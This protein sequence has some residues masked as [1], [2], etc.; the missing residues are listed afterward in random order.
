MARAH[1]EPRDN[2]TAPP[3]MTGAPRTEM[4]S[5]P[6]GQ[7]MENPGFP[8]GSIERVVN[9]MID[10]ITSP[11]PTTTWETI[12]PAKAQEWLKHQHND[13]RKLREGWVVTMAMDMESGNWR[14]SHQGIA[15]DWNGNLLDG[16]HRL[17]AIILANVPVKMM[18]TRDLDPNTFQVT[19]AGHSRSLADRASEPWVSKNTISTARRMMAG[20]LARLSPNPS[21]S[22]VM[23]Y[24]LQHKDAIQFSEGL[25]GTGKLGI[26]TAP[27]RAVVARAYYTQNAHTLEQFASILYTG[28]VDDASQGAAVKL[29]DWLTSTASGVG[30]TKAAEQ[31]ARIER[32]LLAFIEGRSL[33]KLYATDQELF[34]APGDPQVEN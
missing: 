30:R 21:D 27:V 3:M 22:Q 29:R 6:L 2:S 28:I 26:S 32:A 25:F 17:N 11:D 12:T 10:A 16:Q 19:D 24:I 23:E 33:T 1:K 13:Q 20:L 31:Y 18:V 8:A 5:Y 9:G 14:E 15:F 4:P 34:P 7:Y